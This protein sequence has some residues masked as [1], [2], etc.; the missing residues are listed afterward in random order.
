MVCS[1]DKRIKA[2]VLLGGGLYGIPS[3][4]RE[5][6][7]L[8]KHIAMPVQMVNGRSDNWGQEFLLGSFATSPDRRRFVQFDS[9]HSLAGFAKDVIRVNLEWFDRFLGPVR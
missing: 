6:M 7:G 4:D 8:A 3:I 2:A 1:V 9:D 5:M